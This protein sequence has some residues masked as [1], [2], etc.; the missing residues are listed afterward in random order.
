MTFRNEDLPALFH[1]TDQAA[2]SRQ[3][4]STQATRAQLVLL[5]AAAGAAALPSGPTVASLHL[6][7]VLSVLA[8]AG[9]LAVGVRATRRRARPQWQLNR[10][11]AEFIKSLAW[12]YA[13]HGAPFG[14]EV[15]GAEATYRT[16]LEKG[17]DE[18]RKMGWE[19]PRTAGTVPEGGEITGA[20]HR[21]RGLEYQVRRETYV[22]DRL[23]E[24][25]NW[26]RRKTEVSRRATALWS[27]TIV[28]LTC[29]GLLF[30]LLGAFGSGPG[31]RL[32]GLLSS[33]AAAAIAWNEVRRH[34]PLIE[35]H[36]LIEQDLATMMVVMQT[37]ITESHWPSAVYETE[38]YVSP[39]HTDWLAR[40]SS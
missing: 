26:Y 38:R 21:L 6:F 40:H 35:A 15:S 19:D 25:R 17:L 10:S 30:A 3:R 12:R 29:L 33:A 2:V 4:E 5:V 13:V 27:W 32:T 24:Q 28:L 37:T 22:R 20:M 39:Q 18:L 1:H 31:P 7:G 11:A 14:S 16:R 23:I 9:V 34:H 36:T 8:Y